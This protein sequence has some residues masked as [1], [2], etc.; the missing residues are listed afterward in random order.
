MLKPIKILFFLLL[1][2][3][4]YAQVAENCYRIY[5]TDKN[6]N[7]Y[8]INNPEEFLSEKAI[9]RRITY[10]IDIELNDLPVSKY[11]L[12]SLE[13]LGL[14]I[15]NKSKWLNTVVVYSTD[16][17]L[18]DT[19]ENYSF[20]QSVQ[21]SNKTLIT[22]NLSEN[23]LVNN[24]NHIT[25]ANEN[26]LDYGYGVTQIGM[27]NGHTLHKSGYLGQNMTIAVID[28]GFYN[29]DLLPAFDSLRY[30]N[31]ILGTKDFV[32]GDNQVFNA[33]SHGMKVL[34]IMAS[35]MPGKLIG[36]APKANYWLLRSEQTASEYSI[37]EDNW[38]SAAEF[39]DSVG[40]DIINSSLGYSEFDDSMQNYSYSEMDGNTAAIT[41]AADIAASKGILV[42]NSAGN[43]G[44]DPWRYISAPADGDSVL[45][46][47]AV[48][49][50]A[51]LAYFSSVGPTSDG[52]IKPNVAA[53]GYRT[54]LQGTDG[55]ITYSNGTS[56]STPIIAG[57]AA[58]LWQCFPE[59][60]NM[61]II[62]KIQQSA[63]QYSNPDNEL[64]YG[65]PDFG[66]AAE[67]YNTNLISIIK[68]E[69]LIKTYPN[70][71]RDQIK[72]EFLIKIN[73]EITIE[74]YNSTGNKLR[75]KIINPNHYK[76]I[77]SLSKLSNYSPGIYFLK[78]KIGNE[79]VTKIISKIN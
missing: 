22:N 39:A 23:I 63:H 59:L 46:V 66:I 57:M 10:N 73:E 34:S 77:V 2:S 17:D 61:Q 40:A 8:N 74:L 3:A 62:E 50:Y 6:N 20:I 5:L 42:V 64:G 60:N 44:D 25:K 15:L 65:I 70:P 31:Q 53:M 58:C 18:I 38:I 71:F 28:A 37:E 69:A 36:T 29:V 52:R 45:T 67:L 24:N 68:N 11:Y 4:T 7:E 32:D 9:A 26:D 72:V 55:N 27:I 12:D 21:K 47:G 75:S 78:I 30:N 43:L 35:N 13:K 79:Y 19:I 1:Y 48:D 49:S 76:T 33:S 14:S 54:A 56:F 51:S 41:K 16:K